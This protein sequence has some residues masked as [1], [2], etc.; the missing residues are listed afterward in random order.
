MWDAAIDLALLAE[1]EAKE[2]AAPVKEQPRTCWGVLYWSGNAQ[3]FKCSCGYLSDRRED[4][5]SHKVPLT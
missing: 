1:R 3:Q 4:S 2:K 5:E